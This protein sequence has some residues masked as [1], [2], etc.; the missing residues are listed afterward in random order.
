MI[1][2]EVIARLLT[3]FRA[4]TTFPVVDG[5]VPAAANQS[6]LVLVGSAGEDE[7][8]GII[9][10]ELSDL[11]PGGWRN[12]IGEVVCSVFS[13]RG[14]GDLPARRAAALDVARTLV[15]A[16]EADRTLGGLLRGP[17]VSTVGEVIYEPRQTEQGPIV[18][19][20]FSVTYQHLDT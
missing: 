19:V 11:G 9:T 13:W 1:L 10:R 16:V 7:P 15:D 12:E 17:G 2:N 8:G 6:D 3:L 14:G 5:P 20:Q 4:N 18:R